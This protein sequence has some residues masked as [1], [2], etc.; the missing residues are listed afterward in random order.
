M[1]GR[2]CLITSWISILGALMAVFHTL[3]A[4]GR[5]IR[6]TP[7]PPVD[8]LEAYVHEVIPVL[9]RAEW[10]YEH[11]LEQSALF[12]DSEKLGNVAAIHRWETA[13]MGRSLER[14]IPPSVLADAHERV[15]DALEL[16]SRAAQL[17]SNGSRYHNA[18]AVCE[19]QAM[20]AVSRERRLAALKSMR[21]Y[22]SRVQAATSPEAGAVSSEMLAE[23]GARTTVG[24][25][26][27]PGDGALVDRSAADGSPAEGAA[28]DAAPANA[29]QAV[30]ASGA[31]PG[32][33]WP[34]GAEHDLDWTDE[35]EPE[36]AWLSAA[37]AGAG[38]TET[39]EDRSA[40]QGSSAAATGP[41][42]RAGT[43]EAVHAPSDAPAADPLVPGAPVHE[44]SARNGDV[45]GDPAE[46]VGWGSLFAGPPRPP[47]R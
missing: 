6:K 46:R 12:T 13:T 19:G 47:D 1:R 45:G 29:E 25:G 16:A 37:Q 21:H 7:P 41:T 32:E 4:I 22:L 2:R 31:D 14:V 23:A 42:E 11:W 24:G 15:I 5:F 3:A 17:L 34:E 40:A 26:E 36:P 35:A 27:P 38:R 30:V 10:L 20:L 28:L 18:N 8:L 44:Q 33:V 43:A 39:M 9:D